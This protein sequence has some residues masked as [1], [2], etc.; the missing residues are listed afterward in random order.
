MSRRLLLVTP[1]LVAVA[2]LAAWAALRSTRTAPEWTTGS[3][4]ALAA[5]EEGLAAERKLY[6]A[7][8]REHFARAV[9][10]DPG[11]VSARVM[12]LRTTPVVPGDPATV[13]A[14]QALVQ[15]LAQQ[16]KSRLTHR[17]AFLLDYHVA[18][19]QGRRDDAMS[20]LQEY[21]AEHPDDPWALERH[22][23]QLWVQQRFAEA[24]KTYERLL[25]LEPNWVRAQNNLGY[26]AMAQGQFAAAED[27]FLTYRYVAPDQA[28]PHDS[29]GE[30]LLL[31]GRWEDARRELEEAL[32]LR[33]DFCASYV[34]LSYLALF[35]G[36]AADVP[37]ILERAASEGGC[38]GDWTAAPRCRAEL[39]L[40]VQAGDW[41]R[42][43]DFAGSCAAEDRTWPWVPHLAAL[44]RGD[45][46]RA[47]A[48]E[49]TVAAILAK[50]RASEERPL[51]EHLEGMRQI[52]EGQVDEG[53]D[54]LRATD[55]A[56]SYFGLQT[57][58]FKLYNRLQ[59]ADALARKGD[60]AAAEAKLREVAA[61]NPA[62]VESFR[63]G[64]L[65]RLRLGGGD[66]PGAA[67][68]GRPAP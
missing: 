43:A 45:L 56:L 37:A 54:K 9:E 22:C 29:L 17:E 31:T 27:R 36:Q 55:G 18:G 14:R 44:K 28:N 62:F 23:D 61:V 25:A 11:F 32:A 41:E 46:E 57:G 65:S 48:I 49:E 40:Q 10:L 16:D 63:G 15:E 3:P 24:E 50:E 4:A 13:A 20:R 51:L 6:H 5:F 33:R 38:G 8:A 2:A 52:A 26:L 30:L 34:N 60:A 7:E 35:T 64:E 1:V 12:L 47:R 67:A 58:V 21:L 59:W 68:E 53:V 39:W 66:R 19:A 42:L